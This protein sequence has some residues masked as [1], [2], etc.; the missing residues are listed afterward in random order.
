MLGV[1]LVH[2]QGFWLLIV[3]FLVLCEWPAIEVFETLIG[4]SAA[5]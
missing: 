2:A 3:P 1:P 5:S 4:Q